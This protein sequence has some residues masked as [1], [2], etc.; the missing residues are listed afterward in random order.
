M[1][2]KQ[3]FFLLL[4]GWLSIL[5]ACEDRMIVPPFEPITPPPPSPAGPIVS[6]AG[7][8]NPDRGYHLE[9]ANYAQKQLL[10]DGDTYN[11]ETDFDTATKLSL[12]E[13]R[14]RYGDDNTTT[15][16]QLYIYLRSWAAQDIP[17]SGLAQIQKAFDILKT[18]GYKAILRFSYDQDMG[19]SLE[20]HTWISRH[21]QQLKPVLQQNMGQI[22]VV[23]AGF[24][25]AWGEWH[26]SNVS[27]D[28]TLRNDVV[29][30]LL[31]IIPSPY[32]LEVRTVEIKNAL[33]LTQPANLSRIGIHSDFFTAGMDAIDD[34]SMPGAYYN[35]IQEESPYFY[36]RGEIPYE[37]DTYGFDQKMNINKVMTILRDQHFSA[38]DITQNFELNITYWKTQKVYPAL[39][40]ANRILYDSTYFLNKDVVVNRSFYDFVRDHL[41]YRLNLKNAELQ[42]QGSSLIYNIQLTNTGFA[43]VINP[44]DV[45]LVFVD[46]AGSISKEIRLENVNPSDWQPFAPGG[47]NYQLLVHSISGNVSVGL[48]GT[49][50][51]GLWLPDPLNKYYGSYDILWAPGDN[52]THWSDD[53]QK[54]R[55]NI[56]G[57][58]KF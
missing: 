15:L 14:A 47:N 20:S 23:E 53:A 44:H 56:I 57:T 19:E 13:I 16:I 10:T 38:F 2:M 34:L 7:I 24:I 17:A 52:L 32:N 31:D 46:N 4:T 39:L 49:F 54:Y 5:S 42:T 33:T 3:L 11:Q 18:N 41:G 37:E 50:Q 51:V 1:L 6:I 48:S 45:Y 30:S 27:N 12:R 55:L 43:T 9:F 22:A 28:Q 40:D 26:S 58:V 35:Q 21:L 8:A 29:N 36:M 25:G